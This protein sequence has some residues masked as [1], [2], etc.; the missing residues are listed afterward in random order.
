M[1]A[2]VL[3]WNAETNAPEATEPTEVRA[4]LAS[5]KYIEYGEGRTN[6]NVGAQ[7]VPVTLSDR[8]GA[9]LNRVILGESVSVDPY[10]V[11][12]RENDRALEEQFGSTR[13]K[14]KSFGE[15]V[16]G[17]L[18]LG[19]AGETERGYEADARRR[20]N[21]GYGSAGEL[22][23][24]VGSIGV[25][26]S[27]LGAVGKLSSAA[28]AR[29]TAKLG[30][31][32]LAKAAGAGVEG[33][34]FGAIDDG[35]HQL[36]DATIR[37]RPFVAEQLSSAAGVG[38]LLGFG[39]SAALSGAAKLVK[40]S[41]VGA[42]DV[43]KAIVTPEQRAV[44]ATAIKDSKG[45]L[46][47]ALDTHS[48]NLRLLA[49]FGDDARAGVAGIGG[50]VEGNFV[51]G[52][53]RD[54]FK[55]RARA[56]RD[57]EKARDAVARFD[58]E[59]LLDLDKNG[60][61]AYAKAWEKYEGAMK[62]LDDSMNLPPR[63]AIRKPVL[64]DDGATA[65]SGP[66][67]FIDDATQVSGA[68]SFV[69]DAATR[70]DA[71]R[72]GK[73]G[74]V[75]IPR[76][77]TQVDDSLARQF[78]QDAT[79]TVDD[80]LARQFAGQDAT[81]VGRRLPTPA[82][83]GPE[84]SPLLRQFLDNWAAGAQDA[85]DH[86]ILNP[87]SKAAGQL[88]ANS[89]AIAEAAGMPG[90]IPGASGRLG[91][92]G[93]RGKSEY[94]DSVID[95]WAATNFAGSVGKAATGNTAALREAKLPYA[96]RR[97]AELARYAARRE[98][99]GVGAAGGG[100]PGFMAGQAAYALVA[101]KLGKLIGWADSA[102]TTAAAAV[103]S[104]LGSGRAMAITK[105]ATAAKVS[106]TGRDEDATTNARDKGEQL[107]NMLSNEQALR[108]RIR[109]NLDPIAK[110]SPDMATEMEEAQVMRLKNLA[111]KAPAFLAVPGAVPPAPYGPQY[112][113]YNEYEAVTLDPGKAIEA[114]KTN[115]LTRAQVDGMREQHPRLYQH[116]AAEMVKGLTP[117]VMLN[118]PKQARQQVEM[119][120]GYGLYP[121]LGPNQQAAYAA[122][123]AKSQQSADGGPPNPRAM[124]RP[125]MGQQMSAPLNRPG[126]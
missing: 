2:Q 23:G 63:G 93:L 102:K 60:L 118:L 25:S 11:A 82:A 108:E 99:G 52:L 120:L 67:S 86:G 9:D 101:G 40:A 92:D 71:P 103:E 45:A 74:T 8:Q 58:P 87:V 7:S 96:Q 90:G 75:V 14:V 65:V 47:T 21:E 83:V 113:Y 107:N 111:L 84:S 109:T 38:G 39:T 28:G 100:Y 19:L 85:V 20:V 10:G 53:D 24:V 125:S 105:L 69:D 15:G 114:L 72:F 18:T 78:A 73:D 70:V 77:A 49:A 30:G 29:V 27:P 79:T 98:M 36:F 33:A 116:T 94:L 37:D 43:A 76:G 121:T 57:A 88:K 44:T 48:E 115:S 22:L 119:F 42:Q 81:A 3:L 55:S 26:A 5:G 17:G 1:P 122:T 124:P 54:W 16:L 117:K 89:Q 46:D 106:Y 13:D 61:K 112:D 104:L 62:M 66:P 6:L 110:V 50:T 97:A 31:G 68:P 12:S 35:T 41:R 51:S 4:K 59:K 95:A 123:K 126:N 32:A 80:S 56:I 91:V 34:L 64:L